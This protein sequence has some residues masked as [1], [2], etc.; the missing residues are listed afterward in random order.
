MLASGLVG[1]SSPMTTPFGIAAAGYSA[2][3]YNVITTDEKL[4]DILALS[5]PGTGKNASI[6]TTICCREDGVTSGTIALAHFS[7]QPLVGVVRDELLRDIQQHEVHVLIKCLQEA[8][9][10]PTHAVDT[11][12]HYEHAHSLQKAATQHSK[13]PLQVRICQHATSNTDKYAAL[14][15]SQPDHSLPASCSNSDGVAVTALVFLVTAA[16]ASATDGLAFLGLVT[17]VCL[18]ASDSGSYT[19]STQS[20]LLL[21]SLNSPAPCIRELLTK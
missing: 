5:A 21:V 3:R 4:F 14:K 2:D 10:R 17:R 16:L 1:S 12:H 13:R 6:P 18:L 20:I 15:P 19:T 11:T 9:T 7:K 8:G